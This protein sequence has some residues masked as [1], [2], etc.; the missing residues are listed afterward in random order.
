M[1]AEL[2]SLRVAADRGDRRAQ[3]G[4]GNRLLSQ[5]GFGSAGFDEGLAWLTR[6]AEAG[7]AEAQWYLGCVHLQVT[8]LPDP[9][10]TAARWFERASAQEFAPALDRLADLHLTGLG[11]PADDSA[12][13]RLIARGAR[14]GYPAALATLGYL[15][16]QGL[17]TPWD[18]H[19]AARCHAQAAAVGHAAS[20]FALGLRAA[21]GAG[22]ARDRPLG[23]AL[24]LRAADAEH[25]WAAASAAA[26]ALDATE[27]A[28]AAEMYALLQRNYAEA[29]SMRARYAMAPDAVALVGAREALERHFAV[30]G[31][32]L[33]LGADGRLDI[34]ASDGATDTLRAPPVRFEALA[35][36]PRVARQRGFATREE[37]A[38]MM[39]LAE[40]GLRAPGHYSRGD[41]YAEREVFD[42]VGFNFTPSDG[43]PVIRH[44]ERRIAEAT[45]LGPLQGEPFSVIRYEPGQ[46]HKPHYDFFDA[47]Q[48]ALNR[49]RFG[50]PAGQRL[51]S[52]L[53]YLRAAER[54]G[55]TRYIDAGLT[56]PGEHGMAVLHWN[57]LPDGTPDRRSTHAGL[58]VEVGEK[59]L[60]RKALRERAVF[61]G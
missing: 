28:A 46:Q 17:G 41:S 3:V 37:C 61:G 51:V 33:W 11:V 38:H 14:Q 32:G 22:I 29:N 55:G 18:P 24:L 7:D 57:C 36:S 10:P 4:L 8:R 21:A 48:L 40:A 49:E 50:D 12:A 23:H 15:H 25:P 42:G 26:L 31:R 27:R 5:G 35:S 9:F 52:F 54:G 16:S 19:A 60:A 20:Y 6:A 59:W 1:D 30:L 56:V 13:F 44:L 43:D 58:A 45:R 34:V 2:A 53:V 47:A 39:Q